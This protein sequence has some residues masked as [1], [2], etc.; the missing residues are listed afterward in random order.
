MLTRPVH[1]KRELHSP[2]GRREANQLFK[3]FFYKEHGFDKSEFPAV[4]AW[5]KHG[6]FVFVFVFCVCGA[7][8]KYGDLS[9]MGNCSTTE[10]HP[11]QGIMGIKTSKSPRVSPGFR[12]VHQKEI[13]ASKAWH[14]GEKNLCKIE[15]GILRPVTDGPI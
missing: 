1:N 11:S 2:A 5:W 13:P 4:F 10:L 12:T 14:K 8:I 9:T 7:G 6:R 3:E 15:T